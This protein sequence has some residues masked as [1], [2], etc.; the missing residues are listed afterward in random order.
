ME[1]IK[2]RIRDLIKYKQFYDVKKVVT[3]KVAHCNACRKEIG[4]TEERTIVNPEIKSQ[5]FMLCMDC[6][7]LYFK[8][9]SSNNGLILD[10]DTYKKMME[11]HKH[12]LREEFIRSEMYID[13]FRNKIQVKTGNVGSVIYEDT[14]T[15][16]THLGNDLEAVLLAVLNLQPKTESII[17][18]NNTIVADTLNK[19]YVKQNRVNED[20]IAF[21]KEVIK[22]KE[23]NIVFMFF[24]S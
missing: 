16:E 20:L 15:T 1:D 9:R 4:K 5:R 18:T 17:Y 22:R 8:E 14:T 11:N 21:V 24:L 19:K 23:L 10:D 3:N 12:L 13:G 7:Q 2:Q 6:L